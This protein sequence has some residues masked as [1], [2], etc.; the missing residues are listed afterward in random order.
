VPL[1]R[2]LHTSAR[3]LSFVRRLSHRHRPSTTINRVRQY[4][5]SLTS[6]ALPPGHLPPPHLT[7]IICPRCG[8]FNVLISPGINNSISTHQHSVHP[9]RQMINTHVSTRPRY[10]LSPLNSTIPYSKSL[11]LSTMDDS[12]IRPNDSG[13]PNSFD[14]CRAGHKCGL[15]SSLIL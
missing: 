9:L 12:C 7:H 13:S 3:R 4:I 1:M 11:P 5:S 10:T 15:C 8:S 2:D 6:N 14:K